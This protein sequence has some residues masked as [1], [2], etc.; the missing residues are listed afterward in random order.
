MH[1]T[2][3]QWLS[4]TYVFLC[5]RAPSQSNCGTVQEQLLVI[6]LVIYAS[7]KLWNGS[8][9]GVG[10]KLE[11]FHY[12]YIFWPPHCQMYLAGMKNELAKHMLE[13]FQFFSLIGFTWFNFVHLKEQSL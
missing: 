6:V 13:Y 5:S 1:M 4:A 9:L 3:A 8:L 7:I 2:A 12:V 10:Q 11:H